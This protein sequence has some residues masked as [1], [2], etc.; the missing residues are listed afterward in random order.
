MRVVLH[1]AWWLDSLIFWAA[2]LGILYVV[3]QFVGPIFGINVGFG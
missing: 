3:L 1:L 2:L